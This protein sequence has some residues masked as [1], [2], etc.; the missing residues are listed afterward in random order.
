VLELEVGDVAAIVDNGPDDDWDW[1]A[2]P[3]RIH[4]LAKPC[5]NCRQAFEIPREKLSDNFR[6]HGVVWKE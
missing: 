5:P 2:R 6:K 1:P 3:R 4:Y